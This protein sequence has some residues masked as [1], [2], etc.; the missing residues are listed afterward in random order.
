MLRD[1]SDAAQRV[2]TPAAQDAHAARLR[3]SSFEQPRRRPYSPIRLR[4]R[5]RLKRIEGSRILAAR[6]PPNS[7]KRD[8]ITEALP[9]AGRP[10]T[11]HCTGEIVTTLMSCDPAQ[12]VLSHL[13][14]AF[15]AQSLP[16]LTCSNAQSCWPGTDAAHLAPRRV[17]LPSFPWRFMHESAFA[18]R[19]R[20]GSRNRPTG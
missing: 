18:T 8:A 1:P 3:A 12:C 15:D 13:F 14:L 6:V 5:K 4:R 17:H 11:H 19:P 9:P 2:S 7:G 16:W 20:V 10:L